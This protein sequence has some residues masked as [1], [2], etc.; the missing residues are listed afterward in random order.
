MTNIKTIIL[1]LCAV[2][3]IAAAAEECAFEV[4]R[5]GR[6]RR[7][8]LGALTHPVGAREHLYA[9]TADGG[10]VYV[11]LCAPTTVACAPHTSV[12]LLTPDYHYVARGATGALSAAPLACAGC[13]P[14]DGITATFNTNETCTNASVCF[15]HLS[16][17]SP[18]FSSFST[19]PI[20]CFFFLTHS[21]TGTPH[22]CSAHHL[23]QERDAL[24][25]EGHGR[26]E[27]LPPRDLR[28]RPR[29]VLCR[30]PPGPRRRPRCPHSP[31]SHTPR[32]SLLR[33]FF[34]QQHTKLPFQSPFFH[35][36][37]SRPIPLFPKA[38]RMVFLLVCCSF[39]F[40]VLF[41]SH[42]LKQA[43]T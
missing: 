43:C 40:I 31:R 13:A 22:N 7:F 23:R 37:K 20:L 14:Q 26:R 21:P 18:F 42:L 9:H 12:C 29:R 24:H 32:R 35:E 30:T 34:Q 10:R 19:T 17:H 11:N 5:N 6:T 3:V 25:R 2:A 15:G 39:S 38:S 27:G 36:L 33:M 28:A 1:G 16:I 4:E 41:P 8:E